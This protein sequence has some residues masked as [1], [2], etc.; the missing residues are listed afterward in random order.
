ME[1]LITII[2]FIFIIGLLVFFHE[3]GHFLAARFSGIHVENFSIGFGSVIYSKVL[4]GTEF[5]L[6]AIPMGGYVS[7]DGENSSESPDGFRNKAWYIKVWVLVA[8]VLANIVITFILFQL[9]LYFNDYRIVLP[10]ISEYGFTNTDRLNKIYPIVLTEVFENGNSDGQLNVGEQIIAI[11]DQKFSSYDD[12][13]NALELNRNSTVKFL[14]FDYL[15]N[16]TYERYVDIKTETTK[17]GGILQVMAIDPN[18]DIGMPIYIVDYKKDFIS[19]FAM[20]WDITAFQFNSLGYMVD[21]ATKTGDYTEVSNAVGG[22]IQLGGTVNRVVEDE[23]YGVLFFL[24]GAIS[25]SLGVFNLIPFPALDGGQIII[26][27][28]ETLIRRKISD[29]IVNVIN[30]TGFVVLMGISIL[31]AIKDIV[32][33]QIIDSVFLYVRSIMGK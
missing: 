23:L 5:K 24:V 6:C 28:L 31:V 21:K 26:V 12:F 16:E 8:G 10:A 9:H 17:G 11:N 18:S 30:T 14:F 19:T 22:P 13:K 25:L 3:L 15:R 33:L 20:S 29:N 27:L 32:Q 2:I 4:W 7:I 1:F